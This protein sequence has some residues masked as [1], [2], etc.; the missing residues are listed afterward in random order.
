MANLSEDCI[1]RGLTYW[2]AALQRRTWVSWWKQVGHVPAVFVAQKANGDLG[3]IKKSM[4]SRL[5]EAILLLYCALV[6]PH[7]GFYVHF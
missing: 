7:L 1:I 3:S 6:R 2:K 5:R 4:A